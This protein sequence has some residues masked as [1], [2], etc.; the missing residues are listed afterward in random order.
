MKSSPTAPPSPPTAPT[1]PTAP[2]AP[3]AASVA[4]PAPLLEV[5]GLSKH[6]PV[7]RGVF[8]RIVGWVRAVTDVSFSVRPGETFAL[9]GESGCGKTTTG[10]T[11][12]QLLEPTAGQVFFKGVE[13]TALSAAELL[14]YRRRMQIVF[15][16]PVSSL[17]PRMTVEQIVMEGP[18]IHGLVTGARARKERA[19]ELLRRVGLPPE[20]LDRY[21]HEF[22]GGQRQRVGIARALAVE[23]AFIVCDEPVSALDVSVQAQVINL[24]NDLQA[25]TGISYLFV[26]HDLSVVEHIAHRVGVMYLGRMMETAPAKELFGDPRHPYTRALLAAAPQPVVGVPKDRPVLGGEPPSPVNPPPGCPFAPRCPLAQ[27]E[28]SRGTP[29]LEQLGGPEHFVRCPVEKARSL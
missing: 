15:Q 27:P 22:S 7:R 6:F 19:A 10:R 24:L 23:P 18:T 21:P 11:L 1:A 2:V 25:E 29:P 9:V 3:T 14:P 28:C 17:N 5:R 4:E 16:D 8:K 26:A 13:L 20:A 12:L